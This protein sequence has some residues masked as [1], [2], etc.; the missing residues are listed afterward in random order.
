MH[1]GAAEILGTGLAATMTKGDVVAGTVIFDDIGIIDGKIG[2]TLLEVGQGIAARLHGLP[3]QAVSY[4]HSATRIVDKLGLDFVPSVGE[5]GLV[6][7]GERAKLKF[8]S[9]PGAKLKNAFSF[10]NIAFLTHHAIVFRTEAF[11]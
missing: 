4:G 9:P 10:A 3:N 11:A 8:F 5:A 6:R 2:G 1:H 7:R